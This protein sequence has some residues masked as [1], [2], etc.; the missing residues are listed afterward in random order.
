M[1]VNS[2]NECYWQKNCL[3]QGRI[4]FD[5][6]RAGKI[7]WGCLGFK[8]NRLSF[9]NAFKFDMDTDEVIDWRIKNGL[10]AVKDEKENTKVSS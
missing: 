6:I 7:W 5:S 4:D 2:C 8:G 1:S 10:E 3:E 9:V